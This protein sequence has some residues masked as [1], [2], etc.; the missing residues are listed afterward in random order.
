M[1]RLYTIYQDENK[2]IVGIV[3][4]NDIYYFQRGFASNEEAKELLI[5]AKTQK[6]I[7]RH[8]NLPKSLAREFAVCK[9]DF[10]I[11]GIWQLRSINRECKTDDAVVGA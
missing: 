5:E 6:E 9:L 3:I 2:M 8:P 4:N 11:W 7:E 1:K 10:V